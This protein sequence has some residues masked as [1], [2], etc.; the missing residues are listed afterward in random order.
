MKE[1]GQQGEHSKTAE[2]KGKYRDFIVR[3]N[4]EEK[5]EIFKI[6]IW[7]LR[8]LINEKNKKIKQKAIKTIS[9]SLKAG[10]H[11][12]TGR[13]SKKK[14]TQNDIIAVLNKIR[15]EV[16]RGM[17]VDEIIKTGRIRIDGKVILTSPRF[18]GELKL[19][20]L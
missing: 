6:S 4:K 9:K 15:D 13:Y 16:R 17:I 2:E 5:R 20:L 1:A 19:F 10:K 18:N 8:P 7:A 14:L 3:L 11:P 12:I